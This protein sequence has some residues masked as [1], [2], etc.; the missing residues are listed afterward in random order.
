MVEP[1]NVLALD[2]GG[3]TISYGLVRYEF[4]GEKPVVLWRESVS[5]FE[6]GSALQTVLDVVERAMDKG[7]AAGSG[8]AGGGAA[9]G[10][11]AIAAVGIG[12]RGHVTHEG[13]VAFDDE[14][15]M[16]GWTG[17]DLVAEI[18]DRFGVPCAVLNDVQAYALGEA[19]WGA[20][21]GAKQAAVV[22]V[23]TGLGGALVKDGQL[24]RGANGFASEWGH[25]PCVQAAGI[26]CVCGGVAHLESVAAGSGIS[27]R[28][29]D[30]TGRM[31]S[32]KEIDR[33]SGEG[34]PYAR[35][36]MVNA[37]MALGE[38]IVGWV[39]ALD[40]E[41]VC[42]AGSVTKAGSAWR[43][44]FDAALLPLDERP[45]APVVIRACELGADAALIGAAE[46]VRA[47]M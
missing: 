38:A 46:H 35:A 37:G 16:P 34:D 45:C 6:S 2:I 23:G 8:L 40:L 10:G 32:A 31:L 20:A 13:V 12:T 26:P 33:L 42:L 24:V 5:T 29:A 39:N 28:Y 11:A 17:V 1:I 7:G 14:T 47:S 36:V 41:M 15:L 18:R 9:G 4:A 3:T 43:Y 27:A 22:A 19:A 30:M 21:K 44:A 25:V